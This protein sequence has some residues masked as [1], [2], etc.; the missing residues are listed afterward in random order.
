MTHDKSPR[1]K[2][3][4]AISDERTASR[5]AERTYEL[6]T[7]KM[8]AYQLGS[9]PAPTNEDFLLWSRIVEQRVK[10]KQIG[11]EPGGEQRR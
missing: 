11:L 3:Q 10:M 2:L 5:E 9:G 1:E 7:A 6:L 4:E 8:R